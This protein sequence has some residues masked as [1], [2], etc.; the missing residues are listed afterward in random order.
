MGVGGVGRVEELEHDERD[1]DDDEGG[2][3]EG[4]GIKS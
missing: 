2:D 3:E 4:G 1:D